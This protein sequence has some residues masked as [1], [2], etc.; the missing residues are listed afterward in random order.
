M[1]DE[2]LIKAY[3]TDG[4]ED[5]ARLLFTRHE[6]EI[7]A[8]LARML[9]QVQ[10]AEDALQSALAKAWRGLTGY[11]ERQQFKS[12]LYAI[13]R[14]EALMILRRRRRKPEVATDPVVIA[15]VAPS[16]DDAAT[17]GLEWDEAAAN[18]YEAIGQL[19]ELEREVVWLRLKSEMSF[20]NIPLIPPMLL[21]L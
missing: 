12:W 21:S 19:P 14:R 20:S 9:G 15:S 18:L 11:E 2:E 1:T 13:A 3:M 17:K 8:Y 5:L 16:I 4:N 6:S 10:D 7:F